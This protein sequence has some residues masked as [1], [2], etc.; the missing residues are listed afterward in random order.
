M[1]KSIGWCHFK[2][3]EFEFFFNSYGFYFWPVKIFVSFI[4][5]HFIDDVAGVISMRIYSCSGFFTI[6]SYLKTFS[7][8]GNEKGP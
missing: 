7:L 1:K 6:T 8:D 3:Y 5:L 2:G 4:D